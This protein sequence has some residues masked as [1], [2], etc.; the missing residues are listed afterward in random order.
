ME[1]N[2]NGT[3]K[4]ARRHGGTNAE[5][6]LRILPFTTPRHWHYTTPAQVTANTPATL[7]P[8]PHLPA[9]ISASFFSL[10]PGSCAA[11]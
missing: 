2:D 9:T 3:L 6:A 4:A 1:T 10:L 5:R 8:V 7:A 11:L